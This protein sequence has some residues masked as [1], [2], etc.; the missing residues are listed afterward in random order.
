VRN[1]AICMSHARPSW[2]RIRLRLCRK[3]ELPMTIAAT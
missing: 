2:N 3:S 1:M